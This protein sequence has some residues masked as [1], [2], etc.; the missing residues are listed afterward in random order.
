MSKIIIS[1]YFKC[2]LIKRPLGQATFKMNGLAP[3]YHFG[4]E[5]GRSDYFKIKYSAEACISK[6]A[7]KSVLV[8]YS[9]HYKKLVLSS[10]VAI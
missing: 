10:Q 6:K 3:L 7:I 5:A 9:G 4:N 1:L 2:Q 8:R